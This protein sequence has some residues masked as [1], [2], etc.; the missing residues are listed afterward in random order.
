MSLLMQ[1]YKNDAFENKK[2]RDLQALKAL[3]L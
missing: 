1:Q 3:E 2:S